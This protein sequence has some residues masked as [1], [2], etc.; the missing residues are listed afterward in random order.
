[1]DRIQRRRRRGLHTDTHRDAHRYAHADSNKESSIYTNAHEGGSYTNAHIHTNVH[2]ASDADN[3][4]RR[5]GNEGLYRI[6]DLDVY[7]KM[8]CDI[9]SGVLSIQ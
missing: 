4:S 3:S 1:M 8:E 5:N 6:G 7:S 9:G 2:N